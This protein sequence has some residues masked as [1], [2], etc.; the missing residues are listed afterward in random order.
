[1]HPP[2][3][4]RWAGWSLGP[5]PMAGH[6]KTRGVEAIGCTE[7]LPGRLLPSSKQA[8]AAAAAARPDIHRCVPTHLVPTPANAEVG[9]SPHR[10]VHPSMCLS[11]HPPTHLGPDC[12]SQE[13]GGCLPFPS[14]PSL[15]PPLGCPPPI[16]TPTA[17]ALLPPP[18]THRCRP[19]IHPPTHLPTYKA[20]HGGVDA[21]GGLAR[22]RTMLPPRPPRACL[23]PA[24]RRR[25][26]KERRT[27]GDEPVVH[28]PL[29]AKPP[30][31]NV[32]APC[33]MLLHTPMGPREL[34]ACHASPPGA[35]HA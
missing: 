4:T 22:S 12:L 20:L 6:D 19:P 29:L 32:P 9:H 33:H 5:S 2:V 18:P 28:S 1:M 26:R 8:A 34:H 31:P 13:E 25:R 27:R 24:G 7:D 3:P 15:P 16:A 30:R 35:G 11:T 17:R 21:H 23:V 10:L 14:P